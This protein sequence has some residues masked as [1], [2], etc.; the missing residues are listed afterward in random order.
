LQRWCLRASPLLQVHTTDTATAMDLFDEVAHGDF[1]GESMYNLSEANLIKVR[2]RSLLQCTAAMDAPSI[3]RC[4]DKTL[5][6]FTL[7]QQEYS[8]SASD[9]Y[10]PPLKLYLTHVSASLF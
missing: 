1:E 4:M 9:R 2:L 3:K 6:C 7:R 8:H 5:Y 10:N